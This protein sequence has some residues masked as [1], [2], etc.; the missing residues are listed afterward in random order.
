VWVGLFSQLT[1]D[2]TRENGLKLYQE[3]FR[4]DITKNFFTER[5]VKH[6]NGLPREMMESPSL[7][8]LKRCIDA[9]L[10]DIVIVVDFAVLRS[11]SP[12]VDLKVLS[13][14]ND[15]MILDAF[16]NMDRISNQKF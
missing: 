3:R 5:V 16:K 10:R 1:S 13:N 12:T 8:V 4:L 6:W 2:R 15:P 14:Q 9:V 7:E 11:S